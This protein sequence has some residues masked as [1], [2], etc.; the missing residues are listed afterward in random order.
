[1]SLNLGR[2]MPVIRHQFGHLCTVC[3]ADLVLRRVT[4]QLSFLPSA[5]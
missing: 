5:G 1:M 3:Q 4:G 2:L